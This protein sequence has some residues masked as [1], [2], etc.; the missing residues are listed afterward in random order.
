MSPVGRAVVG[1]EV[2]DARDRAAV[3]PASEIKVLSSA[4]GLGPGDFII[5]F[6]Q[7]IASAPA[8]WITALFLPLEEH[9]VA[10]AAPAYGG[11]CN[12]IQA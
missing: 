3:M 2:E 4:I 11:V 1:Q 5:E 9:V 8:A 6:E 12:T 10:L 7:F